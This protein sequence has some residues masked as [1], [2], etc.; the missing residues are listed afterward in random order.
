MRGH[1]Q[2]RADVRSISVDLVMFRLVMWSRAGVRHAHRT[3]GVLSQSTGYD[4][5]AEDH[6][7]R[8]LSHQGGGSLSKDAVNRRL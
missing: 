1:T 6:I 5:K 2:S 4:S 7:V 3:G 8:Q